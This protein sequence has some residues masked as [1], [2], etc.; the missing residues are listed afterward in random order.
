[1]VKDTLILIFLKFPTPGE[2]K[3]RLGSEI[4][5]EAAAIV[6]RRLVREVLAVVGQT[7]AQ[8]IRILFDPPNREQ[9][10]KTWLASEWPDAPGNVELVAQAEGDLGAR[11]SAAFQ[12]AFGQGFRKVAA[13]GTDCVEITPETFTKTWERLDEEDVVFGPAADG[14][15]YLIGLSLFKPELFQDIPWSSEET[16]DKSVERAMELQL[17]IGSLPI[18]TDIDTAE[19]WNA[20]K[21]KVLRETP[22][23]NEPLV[24]QP[25]YQERVWGGRKLQEW[26]NRSLPS[27]Q[28]FGESWEMVDR[29]EAQTVIRAGTFA[30]FTLGELWEQRR[31]E[32]FGAGASGDRFPLL[33]KILDA[34]QDLSIQVH[35]PQSAAKALNGEPKTEMWYVAHAMPGAKLYAGLKSGVT[36]EEVEAAIQD[37][38]L[39]DKVH[40]I[41]VKTGDCLFIPSGRIH[42]IG[43]GLLIYE[44]Q[45]NSDTTYRV[46]DWN[47]TGLDGKPRELHVEESLQSIDFE[48]IEPGVAIPSGN[49][50]VECEYFNVEKWELKPG[51]SRI[52][53]GLGEFAIITV[54]Q[55]QIR[56]GEHVFGPGRFFAIPASATGE[57]TLESCGSKT[58]G[59]LRTSVPGA[60][61][62]SISGE[63]VSGHEGFY[64]QLRDRVSEWAATKTGLSHRWLE[65]ILMVPD[66]F[67]LLTRLLADPDVPSK[68]KAA[69][70]GAIAYFVLPFDVVPEGLLGPIGYLDDLALAAFVINRMM[71]DVEPEVVQ[72]NWAG[73]GDALELVRVLLDKA[74]K[75]VGSGLWEKVKSSLKV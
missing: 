10:I 47:R 14:G 32:I 63:F 62:T 7:D 27:D 58:A 40:E 8:Q 4:G 31:A 60:G 22:P 65:Y 39:A 55:G 15:Y 56:C 3:T 69:L 43:A 45:Q 73:E 5:D 25:V 54:I 46:F 61:T 41:E 42:A 48:D 74:D 44:I 12:T 35:P 50:L 16:L 36:R 30:G 6:Y 57:L 59:I 68:H 37:G 26:L 13:I 17:H 1:M 23:L 52:A 38:S 33:L 72:R 66:F 49:T 75:M 53:G 11:M 2:V 64:R 18:S 19:E 24:F 28:P 20:Q 21:K 71:N 67:H 9:D 70:G 29:P 34:T 51:E